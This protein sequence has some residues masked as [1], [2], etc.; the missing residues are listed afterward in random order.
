MALRALIYR[1]TFETG[2]VPTREALSHTAG[3]DL[4]AQLERLHDAH[5]IVLDDRPHRTGEI[6]M[7]LPFA[8]EPT[9]FRVT[10]NGRGW[11]ANCAWD[12]LAVVAAIHQDATIESRWAD[13]GEPLVLNI[14]NQQLSSTE[15]SIYFRIP[16]ARW[17]DDIVET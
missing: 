5:M 1:T 3:A 16:A 9:D 14:T 15:G 8:A 6:R 11:W 12:S 17:W 7:A 10:A 2:E 4:D 13:T